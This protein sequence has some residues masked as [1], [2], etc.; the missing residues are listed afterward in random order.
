M[1]GVEAGKDDGEARKWRR[2]WMC[3]VGSQ[4]TD[5]KGGKRGRKKKKQKE[6]NK[7]RQNKTN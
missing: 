6:T 4:D 5:K 7:T 1:Y 3:G 2:G